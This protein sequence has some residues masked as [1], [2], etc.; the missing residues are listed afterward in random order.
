MEDRS[1]ELVRINDKGEAHPIGVIASRRMRERVGTFRVL[2]SPRHVVLMRYTGE[3]GRRDAED[4]AIVRLSGEITEPCA[5]VD[6]LAMVAQTRTRGELVVLSSHADRTVFLENG[7][8]VGAE[9]NIDEERLGS[10]MYRFG[11]LDEEQHQAVLDRMSEGARFGQAAVE[12]GFAT[13]EQVY[14]YLGKQIE[15]IVYAC[16]A[17]EDG[18][19]FFLEGFDHDRLV[20]H[21]TF[22][23]TMLLMD[24]VTR[25]DEVRYFRQKIPDA[26]WIPIRG[27]RTEPPA[28][29]FRRVY[30]AID[31]KLSVAEVGR[32]SGCGEFETTKAVYALIQSH[33]VTLHPPRTSGGPEALVIIANHALRRIHERLDTASSTNGLRD[34][35]ASF[36]IGAGM[37]EML[38]SEAGPRPDGTFDAERM[39][40]NVGVV[41]GG[42]AEDFLKARL[43]EYVSFAL[44]IAGSAL[45][46]ETEQALSRDLA[47]ALASLQ[48]QGS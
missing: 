36:S 17:L 22:S 40:A 43:H 1:A 9:T 13:S 15:E 32:V 6:V 29:E 26:S 10:V 11:A 25:L 14:T 44:F 34:A 28:E 27:D 18:T 24:A 8:I 41:A 30:E 20:S 45:G 7:N 38:F 42:D 47:E 12:L 5:L 19:F 46:S 16:L 31:G 2:P 37:Y 23:V 39:A 35:L 48:P 21:H 3:D 33:H 4:G